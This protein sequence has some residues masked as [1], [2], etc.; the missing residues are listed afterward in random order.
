MLEFVI[1]TA[2]A[3]YVLRGYFY[4]RESVQLEFPLHD[5]RYYI[6]Q[7][8][9]NFLINAHKTN[10]AQKFALD[11]V[12]L[13][14]LGLRVQG[15]YPSEL[16]RYEIFGET[17]YRPCD[18]EVVEPVN[19]LPDN[20]PPHTD[21]KHLAGNHVVITCRNVKVL[22]AHMMNDSLTVTIPGQ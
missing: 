17:I 2:V 7:G 9:N 19:N 13:N 11:I 12:E 15:I 10:A 21:R 8:G 16:D 4:S 6:G 14:S 3:G 20:I 18:G 1:A 5:G 22:L